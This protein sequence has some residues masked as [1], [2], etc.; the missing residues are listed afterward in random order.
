MKLQT[1]VVANLD[2]HPYTSMFE[3]S[4]RVY[5]KMGLAPTMHTCGGGNLEPKILELYEVTDVQRCS[6]EFS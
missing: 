6:K 2:F 1:I 4:R 5:G 3:Q